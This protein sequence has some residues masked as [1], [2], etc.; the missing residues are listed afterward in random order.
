M[1]VSPAYAQRA[2]ELETY[3]D[4]TANDAWAK[5][6]SDAPVSGI[7]ATVRAGR[8]ETRDTLLGWLGT[9]LS[10]R[11]ILDAGCGPGQ[12]AIEAARRGADVTA[13]DLSPTL[14]AL[15]RDRLRSEKVAGSV[16]FISGD[17][18]CAGPVTVEHAVT[19]DVL[20]HYEIEDIIDVVVRLAE[21]AERSVIFTVAPQTPLLRLMHIV[22][23]AFPKANRAPSIRPVSLRHLCSAL[24]SDERL[25][26][27]RVSRDKC[28]HRG[29]YISHAF[30]LVRNYE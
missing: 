22:G 19:M 18:L 8:A 5:L 16:E 4:R 12:F 10:G 24:G 1:A 25:S 27:W 2:S 7:R 21:R 28:V 20:I 30:E 3:F 26:Q 23:G 6:T 11:R 29:F 15:A 14:L 13:V 17:M 9:D